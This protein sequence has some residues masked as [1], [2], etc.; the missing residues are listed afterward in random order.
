MITFLAVASFISHILAV[1][2]RHLFPNGTISTLFET[3]A[4]VEGL[5][6]FTFPLY[7]RWSAP[8][9]TDGRIQRAIYGAIS[10]GVPIGTASAICLDG[11]LWMIPLQIISGFLFFYLLDKS[12]RRRQMELLEK[13]KK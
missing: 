8:K 3:I 1:L 13:S 12:I 4:I 9:A 7:L 6:I 2:F 5:M 10:L 11:G